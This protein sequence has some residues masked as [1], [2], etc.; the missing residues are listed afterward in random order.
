M[1]AVSLGHPVGTGAG[2][3]KAVLEERKERPLPQDGSRQAEWG[4]RYPDM[5]SHPLQKARTSNPEKLLYTK[6]QGR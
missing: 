2:A 4:C 5:Q 1:R 3:D 6:Q